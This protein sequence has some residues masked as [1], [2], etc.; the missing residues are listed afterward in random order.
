[1]KSVTVTSN[2]APL[3]RLA[4]LLN[5]HALRHFQEGDMRETVR[6]SRAV[7]GPS[8]QALLSWEFLTH[9]QLDV[10]PA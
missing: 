3:L 8:L 2:D 1:M 10:A 6:S 5:P 7:K 9:L 4:G